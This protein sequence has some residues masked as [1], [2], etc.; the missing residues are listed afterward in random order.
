[1]YLVFHSPRLRVWYAVS[2][3][4]GVHVAAI[5]AEGT[6]LSE[7]T[8][9][10]GGEVQTEALAQPVDA[11]AGTVPTASEQSSDL[12]EIVAT[13]TVHA[14]EPQNEVTGA[15]THGDDAAHADVSQ[16]EV[17]GGGTPGDDAVRADGPQNELA[18]AEVAGNEAQD[19]PDP[20]GFAEL[21]FQRQRRLLMIKI[22]LE[23]T[24]ADRLMDL[25]RT[26]Q[27]TTWTTRSDE[28][29]ADAMAAYSNIHKDHLLTQRNVRR[30][31]GELKDL[32]DWGRV[33]LL[34]TLV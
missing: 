7:Q 24:E 32:L 13:V 23:L 9:N 11:S 15:D 14:G 33:R 20:A 27:E 2:K 21:D 29:R 18:V 5:T 25:L 12:P 6:S 34:H 8:Q 17:A 10:A 4:A 19:Q 1:M 31:E 30:L 3:A 26:A 16:N 22:D 28:I